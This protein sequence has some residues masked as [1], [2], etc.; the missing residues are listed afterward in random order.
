MSQ[1]H[2]ISDNRLTD[3]FISYRRSDASGHAGRLER[4][5]SKRFPGRVFMDIHDIEVG[6]DFTEVISDEVGKCG[7]LLVI[8]GNEWLNV[9]DPKT[10]KRRLEDPHDFVATE[11]ASALAR[12]IRVI[13]VL[14]EGA[15]MPQVDELPPALAGLTRRNAIE[16]SD[17]RW[18]YDVEQLIK[19]LEKICGST[20]L[21]VAPPPKAEGGAAGDVTSGKSG[22]LKIAIISIVATLVAVV[23][24]GMFLSS[25]ADSTEVDVN[26]NVAADQ[27][28]TKGA[29]PD[30][31]PKQLGAPQPSD[32]TRPPA[33]RQAVVNLAEGEA[34]FVFPF[35]TTGDEWEWYLKKSKVDEDEYHWEVFVR[36]A[37]NKTDYKITV[38]LQKGA[39]DTTPGIGNFDSIL[40]IA[41]RGVQIRKGEADWGDPMEK[42]V[43]I[44][45]V[46]Q[47]DGL[48]IVLKGDGVKRIFASK[49]EKVTFMIVT[50][51]QAVERELTERVEYK[52]S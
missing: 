26:S 36:D 10:G 34:E 30:G 35:D 50:P 39:D 25:D 20:P 15:R 33:K 27:S 14:V 38:Y 48:R 31:S 52:Q 16:I 28:L 46:A 42:F 32:A 6:K 3:I 7:A 22:V 17:T 44:N 24:L 49:P 29:A 43:Q 11:V 21:P 19:V 2:E 18:D 51:K 8:I 45:P 23:A 1:P 47:P 41:E 9:T 12:N 40:D 37:P 13:P 4:D 5:L